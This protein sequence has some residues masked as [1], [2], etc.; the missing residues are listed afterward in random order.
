MKKLAIALVIALIATAVIAIPAQA[1]GGG[2]G[3]QDDASADVDCG[4]IGVSDEAPAVGTT[5][6]FYGSVTVV[7][8]AYNNHNYSGSHK[9]T[10][11]EVDA[12]VQYTIYDP[13]GT[14]IAS[15]IVHSAGDYDDGTGHDNSYAH[16][17]ETIPWTSDPVLIELVGDYVATQVG[18]VEA[19]YGHWEQDK[20]YEDV[21]V[22]GHWEGHGHHKHWVPGHNE[23]EWTGEWTDPEFIPD[24]SDADDCS[25]SLTVTSR[26]AVVA[27][28]SYSRPYLVIELPDGSKHFF[29]PDGWGD[30]TS[31]DIVYTDGTWQVE[32]PDGTGIQLDGAWHRTTYLEVDDQ[33]NVTG[34]YNAGGSTTATDIGLSQP[35]IITKV[36]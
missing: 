5:I 15:G 2:C 35:M 34:R 4:D 28:T 16:I 26:S 12:Y 14:V 23:S 18:H 22:P 10:Y 30:T 20:V 11:A 33:G 36:G 21:W 17:D 8:T 25:S 32:I 19:V 13:E 1:W 9:G 7:A 31:Q 6:Y 27:S 24:G 29:S 3:D